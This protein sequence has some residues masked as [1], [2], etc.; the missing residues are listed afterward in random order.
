MKKK[1]S[2]TVPHKHA[3]IIK[4]W[5]DGIPIQVA[6]ILEDW[7]DI[8]PLSERECVPEFNK[9]WVYRIK[10]QHLLSDL[11]KYGVQV[12]DVWRLCRSKRNPLGYTCH[13]VA[14]LTDV[15][16]HYRCTEGHIRTVTEDMTLMFRRGEVN[17]L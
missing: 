12:G 15:V 17:K 13:T 6:G 4:A 9:N 10:P 5:A 7:Y 3:K 14:K 2:T 11:E 1:T 8:E 16:N